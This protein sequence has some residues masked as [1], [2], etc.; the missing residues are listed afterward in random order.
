MKTKE[1]LQT[2]ITRLELMKRN[3]TDDERVKI[4]IAITALYFAMG[5]LTSA[6]FL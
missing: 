4:Q 5:Q 6:Y 1:Q 3:A 2:E